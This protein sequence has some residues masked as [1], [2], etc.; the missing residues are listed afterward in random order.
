MCFSIPLIGLKMWLYP[1]SASIQDP[2]SFTRSVTV[3]VC[4]CAGMIARAMTLFLWSKKEKNMSDRLS[5][6]G[7]KMNWLF[8]FV[9]H[10]FCDDFNFY[11]RSRHRFRLSLSQANIYYT[12]YSAA[13]IIFFKKI[14]LPVFRRCAWLKCHGDTLN[15]KK[16][17]SIFPHHTENLGHAVE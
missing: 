2:H 7:Y 17:K 16:K 6:Y 5:Q 3:C 1:K 12:G 10:R 11:A 15:V 9:N 8:F 14:C 13:R 4:V